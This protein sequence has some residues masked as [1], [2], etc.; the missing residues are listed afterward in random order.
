M[1]ITET[2]IRKIVKEELKKVLN[3]SIPPYIGSGDYRDEPDQ[4]ISSAKIDPN[5][6][7]KANNVYTKSYSLFTNPKYEQITEFFPAYKEFQ[8]SMK[9]TELEKDFDKQPQAF[10]DFAVSKGYL[11]LK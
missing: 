7:K 2:Y 9:G 4:E 5:M 8:Q 10:F 6:A 1:R 3:E 11:K